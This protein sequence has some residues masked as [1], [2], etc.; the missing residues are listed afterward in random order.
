MPQISMGNLAPRNTGHRV[1]ATEL[2]HH[3]CIDGSISTRRCDCVEG[4][5]VVD[6]VKLRRERFGVRR[7]AGFQNG[8]L[9][10]FKYRYPGGYRDLGRMGYARGF[11]LIGLARLSPRLMAWSIEPNRRARL[12]YRSAFLRQ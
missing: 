3:V 5:P 10:A 2:E 7:G 6:Y 4:I 12:A 1:F 8:L 9:V 11:G